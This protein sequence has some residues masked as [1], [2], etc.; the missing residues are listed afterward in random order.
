MAQLIKGLMRFAPATTAT[1]ADAE[2]QLGIKLPEDYVNFLT[3]TNGAE[4]FL[5]SS[6]LIL[7]HVE[8]LKRMNESYEVQEY[9]PGFVLIG[10]NGG[11]DAYAFDTRSTRCQIVKIPFIGMD[12]NLAEPIGSLFSDFLTHLR[13]E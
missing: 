11:G 10:S 1:I 9:I 3:I 2:R 13:E 5:G 7:W 4:G 12:S 6:Y 8:D